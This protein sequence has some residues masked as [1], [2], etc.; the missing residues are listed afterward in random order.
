MFSSI[1]LSS[2]YDRYRIGGNL[3]TKFDSEML[4]AATEDVF[5]MKI[6]LTASV[7]ARR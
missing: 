3:T 6:F 1:D 5:S 4:S 2:S 7:N